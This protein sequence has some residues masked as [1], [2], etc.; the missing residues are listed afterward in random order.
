MDPPHGNSPD[1]ARSR[2][3]WHSALSP[4]KDSWRVQARTGR[5]G[6][7]SARQAPIVA[8]STAR[9][10]TGAC[11]AFRGWTARPGRQRAGMAKPR[12]VCAS[13]DPCIPAVTASIA[14]QSP[15]ALPRSRMTSS[16]S[17]ARGRPPGVPALPSGAAFDRSPSGRGGPGCSGP[18][19]GQATPPPPGQGRAAPGRP[20]G[21][22]QPPPRQAPRPCRPVAASP[23][24]PLHNARPRAH[25]PTGRYAVFVDLAHVPAPVRRSI[26]F[27]P[28]APSR[29]LY[30]ALR[31][32][33]A[34]TGISS[35]GPDP[36]RRTTAR[37]EPGRAGFD[38]G[39]VAVGA[40]KA[41]RVR[42]RPASALER[43]TAEISRPA[44][45]SGH[46]A[47]ERLVAAH[48]DRTA[49]PPIEQRATAGRRRARY[50]RQP[51]RGV[52]GP[53]PISHGTGR[54]A[55]D[56]V[57]VWGGSAAP[58]SGQRG[59]AESGHVRAAPTSAAGRVVPG[60]PASSSRLSPVTL[61]QLR[62]PSP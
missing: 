54:N 29:H 12:H 46:I 20:P 2:P 30:A 18:E 50:R 34:P 6:R 1:D 33:R 39:K 16:P 36:D 5:Y 41:P 55:R 59:I 45:R 31:A 26:V 62:G 47:D 17:P 28:I 22:L 38:S 53:R 37:S 52:C 4:A 15:P 58:Q 48:R 10:P 57:G 23:P 21:L 60:P 24:D 3:R 56:R 11:S 19:T 25:A 43:H 49:P 9:A 42:Y 8:G 61:R 7:R 27:R 51:G 40:D 35:H 44:T 13:S 14:S 32:G